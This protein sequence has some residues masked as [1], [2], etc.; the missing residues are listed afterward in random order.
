MKGWKDA[1]KIVQSVYHD[2]LVAIQFNPQF[3]II[4]FFSYFFIY[5][6]VNFCVNEFFLT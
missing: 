4:I 1:I 6:V 2:C 5:F 3:N